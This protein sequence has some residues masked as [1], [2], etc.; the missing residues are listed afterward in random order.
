M[1]L[2][3]EN[4]AIS[5]PSVKTVRLAPWEKSFVILALHVVLTGIN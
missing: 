5:A 3:A 4:A 2:V 1:G